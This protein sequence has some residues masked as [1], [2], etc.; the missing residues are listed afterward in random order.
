MDESAFCDAFAGSKP[1]KH[2]GEV[3]DT[4]IGTAA[5]LNTQG[6][7]DALGKARQAVKSVSNF[8]ESQVGGYNG[9]KPDLRFR[10]D[11]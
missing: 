3:E 1:L 6:L 7:F 9:V 2:V 4:V 8:M 5:G 11:G 10:M